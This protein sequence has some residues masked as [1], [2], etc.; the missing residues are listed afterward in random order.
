MIVKIVNRFG[1]ELE[2][3]KELAEQMIKRGELRSYE[4]EGQTV[5]GEADPVEAPI[6]KPRNI[7]RK[8][9]L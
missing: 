3:T 2:T 8:P 9:K 5:E 1:I 7:T 4:I 6:I